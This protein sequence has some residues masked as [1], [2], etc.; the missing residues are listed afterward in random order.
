V[1]RKSDRFSVTRDTEGS[2]LIFTLK[3]NGVQYEDSGTYSCYADHPEHGAR[4]SLVPLEVY[5]KPETVSLFL[6]REGNENDTELTVMEGSKLPFVCKSTRSMPIPG[7]E[8]WITGDHVEHHVPL[9]ISGAKNALSEIISKWRDVA[10]ERWRDVTDKFYKAT[11]K[12]PYC[13]GLAGTKTCPLHFDYEMTAENRDFTPEVRHDG[14]SL[15]CLV[16]MREFDKENFTSSLSLTVHY[17]PKMVC[18]NILNGVSLVHV[19]TTGHSISCR[20]WAN[21]PFN[22]SEEDSI[23]WSDQP[24]IRGKVKY[25]PSDGEDYLTR[26]TDVTPDSK[27][28]TVVLFF[29]KAIT[30]DH[31]NNKYCLYL[32]NSVG[33]TK[34]DFSLRDFNAP[35]KPSAGSIMTSHMMVVLATA[36]LLI[37]KTTGIFSI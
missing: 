11:E 21:P 13:D 23:V 20:V 32:R 14:Q 28:R 16:S 24:C 25:L 4:Y 27:N 17:Q 33:L 7:M 2:D 19:N 9:D 15:T 5:R 3:I 31:F 26:E 29:K 34:Q 22:K 10:V 1:Y 12:K 30:K 37:V 35:P 36:L 6:N 8:L 18:N